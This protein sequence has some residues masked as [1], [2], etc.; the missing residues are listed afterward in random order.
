M[1][2]TCIRITN[3]AFRNC[4]LLVMDG[5]TVTLVDTQVSSTSIPGISQLLVSGGATVTVV[6][7][8]L[9]TSHSLCVL[10]GGGTIF[11]TEAG[12]YVQLRRCHIQGGQIGVALIKGATFA[13]DQLPCS[14]T[15]MSGLVASDPGTSDELQACKFTCPNPSPGMH[16]DAQKG[17]A[18]GNVASTRGATKGVKAVNGG[19]CKIT[20][21]TIQACT[22]LVADNLAQV[23]VRGTLFGQVQRHQLRSL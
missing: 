2:S 6:D 15:T 23:E 9:S 12:T 22:G 7:T 21:S 4:V 11:A 1:K 19:G 5:A 20:D 17:T 13:A 10:S 16:A 14:G 8:Q 18:E 3:C